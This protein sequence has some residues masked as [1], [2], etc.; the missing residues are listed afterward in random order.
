MCAFSKIVDPPWLGQI[1]CSEF[2]SFT[3]ALAP[4]D[5][6]AARTFGGPTKGTVELRIHLVCGLHVHSAFQEKLNSACAPAV[7]NGLTSGNNLLPVVLTRL[8][9]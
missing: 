2:L 6:G 7:V 3:P 9:L 8:P 5:L 1:F 4:A